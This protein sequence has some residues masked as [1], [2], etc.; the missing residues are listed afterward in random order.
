MLVSEVR[1]G[2]LFMLDGRFCEARG[3][4]AAG[5]GRSAKGGWVLRFRELATRKAREHKF[6]DAA[7]LVVITCDRTETSVLDKDEERVVLAGADY[8]EVEVPLAQ[9]GDAA[10]MIEPGSTVGLLTYKGH[11]V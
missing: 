11:V 4:S 9:L 6:S 1:S 8:N 2:T 10:E 5:H 3:I 7:E